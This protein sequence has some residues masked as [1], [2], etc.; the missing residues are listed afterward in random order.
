MKGAELFDVRDGKVTRLVIYGAR[1]HALADVGLS[2]QDAH[3]DS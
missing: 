1:E 3:A 2:E